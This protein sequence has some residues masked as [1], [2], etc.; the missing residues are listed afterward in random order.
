MSHETWD[1]EFV[2]AQDLLTETLQLEPVQAD[3]REDRDLLG[4]LYVRYILI[5]NRLTR[6]VDQM[7]QPQK[8]LLVK[9]LLE[10]ALG[11]ILELKMDLVEADL[12]E[13]THCGDV[14]EKLSLTPFDVEI[15]VPT[16]FRKDR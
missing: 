6:C 11:R 13:W 4:S 9:K 1:R 10:A 5:A 8:R 14:M 2:N 3:R 7:V 16:C 15:Q 12:N